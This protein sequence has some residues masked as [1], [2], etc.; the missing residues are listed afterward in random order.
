M[1]SEL[2]QSRHGAPPAA[3]RAAAPLSRAELEY[4]RRRA[5]YLRSAA[6]GRTLKSVASALA[7]AYRAVYQA[8]KRSRDRRRAERELRQLDNRT[9]S[10]IGIERSH[11]PFVVDRLLERRKA[12]GNARKAYPLRVLTAPAATR[13]ANDDDERRPPLAA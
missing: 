3:A 1:K 9:L 2:I 13:P 8:L 6:F 12:G 11:I 7:G 10:D 4:Y 5:H